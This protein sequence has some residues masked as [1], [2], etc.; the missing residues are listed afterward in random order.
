MIDGVVRGRRSHHRLG[1]VRGAGDI[2]D[3]G[4]GKTLAELNQEFITSILDTADGKQANVETHAGY[5][6]PSNDRKDLKGFEPAAF[7]SWSDR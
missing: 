6:P 3:P 2:A 7:S 5:G 4:S 1:P